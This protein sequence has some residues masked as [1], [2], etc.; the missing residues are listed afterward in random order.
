[1]AAGVL[2]M[3]GDSC[4]AHHRRGQNAKDGTCYGVTVSFSRITVQP[5]QMGGAPCIRGLRIPVSVIVD[6]VADD[7]PIDAILDLYPDLEREDVPAA[8]KF[9]AEAVRQRQRSVVGT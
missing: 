1:M 7:M 2:R 9:A 4:P 6:M 3:P 5:G 8:L